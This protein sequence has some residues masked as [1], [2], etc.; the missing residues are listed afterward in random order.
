MVISLLLSAQVVFGCLCF[1]VGLGA[2]REALQNGSQGDTISF[3]ANAQVLFGSFC[4]VAGYAL[5]LFSV[6]LLIL[7]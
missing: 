7:G 6:L 3:A 2:L 4:L 1:A 5:A